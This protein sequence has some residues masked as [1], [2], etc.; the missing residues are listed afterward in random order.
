MTTRKDDAFQKFLDEGFVIRKLLTYPVDRLHCIV[1]IDSV[2]GINHLA[3]DQAEELVRRV[4]VS[5]GEE[6]R[7]TIVVNDDQAYDYLATNTI[8]ATFAAA[9]MKPG[10]ILNRL[11]QWGMTPE[12]HR[13][14]VQPAIAAWSRAPSKAY[15][16]PEG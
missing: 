10:A 2:G 4:R 11:T 14:F 7:V 8:P 1:L 13:L 6:R 3:K 12:S 16:Q 9:E 5:Y 15:S